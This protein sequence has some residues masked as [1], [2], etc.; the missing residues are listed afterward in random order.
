MGDNIE[1]D[2]I[3]AQIELQNCQKTLKQLGEAVECASDPARLR[4]LSGD[5]PSRKQLIV[6]IDALEVSV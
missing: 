3:N 6:K 2:L 5:N 4:L 1:M